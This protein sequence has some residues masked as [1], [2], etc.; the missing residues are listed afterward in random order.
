MSR[1]P[2]DPDFEPRVADWLE[3]DPNLAPVVVLNTVLAAFPS[4]PQRRASRVPWRFPPMNTLA[5][6]AVAA[7]AVI[8][9]IPAYLYHDREMHDLVIIGEIVAIAAIFMC[10]GFVTVDL[11]RPDRFW[12]MMP[13][14]GKFNW[15]GS[16]LTWD[17][18]VLNGYLLINLHVVGVSFEH[19][20]TWPDCDPGKLLSPMLASASPSHTRCHNVCTLRGGADADDVN[21]QMT[22]GM[23]STNQCGR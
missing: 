3:D 17:V 9:N 13:F 2:I 14:F 5:N 20:G 12:H 23:C 16:M 7:V 8:L 4:I 15:P 1:I 10:L 21:T 19:F 18:L 22:P 11:G 6:L